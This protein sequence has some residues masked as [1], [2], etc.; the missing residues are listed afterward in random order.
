MP[1]PTEEQHPE[2]LRA[3]AERVRASTFH[4]W[5]GL[6]LASASD[7]ECTVEVAL[8]PHHFNYQ[9][10]VHGGVIATLA[11]TAIG[12]A[13]RTVLPEGRSHRTIQMNVHY[14]AKGVGDRLIGRGRAIH[15]GRSVA[16]GEGEVLDANGRV[17]ARATATFAVLPSSV[18]P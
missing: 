6:T 4:E 16:H 14:L 9:G 5:F 12:L 2:R 7:G 11:D 8:A 13:V 15:V 3:V 10:I 17:I 18:A 1:E